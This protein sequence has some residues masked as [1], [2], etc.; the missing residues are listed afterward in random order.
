ML[1]YDF[2]LRMDDSV[3]RDMADERQFDDIVLLYYIYAALSIAVRVNYI[4]QSRSVVS[5]MY[6]IFFA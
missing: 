6:T 1:S 5:A 4:T 2:V 3:V